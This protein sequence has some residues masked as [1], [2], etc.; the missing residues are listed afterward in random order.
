MKI[1]KISF[2]ISIFLSCFACNKGDNFYEKEALNTVKI[3]HS[4]NNSFFKDDYISLFNEN[5]EPIPELKSYMNSAFKRQIKNYYKGKKPLQNRIIDGIGNIMWD[6][7]KYF[8]HDDA[9]LAVI[10]IAKTSS[11]FTEG[12][13]F[14]YLNEKN[15]M[16]KFA[17]EK[18]NFFKHL[19]SK[20][21]IRNSENKSVDLEIILSYFMM[22]DKDVFEYYDCDIMDLYQKYLDKKGKNKRLKT[23]CYFN[24][25]VVSYTYYTTCA[26]SNS[27][28]NQY[29][30]T[31][32]TANYGWEMYCSADDTYSPPANGNGNTGGG[33]NGNN[34]GN[35]DDEVDE[36]L[37]KYYFDFTTKEKIFIRDNEWTI[38]FLEE[39]LE[40]CGGNSDSNRPDL[41]VLGNL[42]RSYLNTTREK[43]FFERYWKGNGDWT[44]PTNMFNE[45]KTLINNNPNRTIG[46][47]S[48][49]TFNGSPALRYQFNGYNT[50]YSL[51]LGHF[52]YYT[53]MSGNV[54]GISDDYNFNAQASEG[55]T[56]QNYA[57][58]AGPTA[59]IAGCTTRGFL[60]EWKT[61]ATGVAGLL[62]GAKSYIVKYP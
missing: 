21:Q 46:G 28:P 18:R 30:T 51:A 32:S 13:V 26:G 41:G 3:E 10:P 17:Y 44:I 56:I 54:I 61:R 59:T 48:N 39:Y 27:N 9:E 42:I 8:K 53:D 52:T 58:L 22:F 24:Y 4:A 57:L 23:Y 33:N 11:T 14:A 60:N 47:G 62:N 29:C 19:P 38:D 12:L 2:A 6:R 15:D 49:V 1:L 31:Y 50:D 34:N 5:V 55:I 36:F 7:A 40:N 35:N 43:Q 20:I 16:I 37:N 45:L 25:E